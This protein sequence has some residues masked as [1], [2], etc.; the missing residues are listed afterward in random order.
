MANWALQLISWG[1]AAWLREEGEGGENETV[2]LVSSLADSEVEH[3][4]T[5]F[6]SHL[7]G[8]LPQLSQKCD[9]AQ[10]VDLSLGLFSTFEKYQDGWVVKVLNGQMFMYV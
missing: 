8:R 2:R 1:R 3:I 4:F 9:N 10:T 5:S 6:F 7:S